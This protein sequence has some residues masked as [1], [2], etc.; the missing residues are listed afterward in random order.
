MTLDLC[1]V[2]EHQVGRG[3]NS[4]L[5]SPHSQHT[6]TSTHKHI[7]TCTHA[8][9]HIHM[10]TW[11]Q[12]CMNTH[13]HKHAYELTW[14]R[15]R[16]S[17]SETTDN[18]PK[19]GCKLFL[20]LSGFSQESLVKLHMCVRGCFR[21]KA[22]PANYTGFG[23][24][25]VQPLPSLLHTYFKKQSFLNMNLT[26]W[27][28]QQPALSPSVC[29][30]GRK[31]PWGTDEVPP[32]HSEPPA[33]P[34]A[35]ASE[36]L[37]HSLCTSHSLTFSLEDEPDSLAFMTVPAP[38]VCHCLFSLSAHF[39]FSSVGPRTEWE[40]LPTPQV[41]AQ[42]WSQEATGMNGW[43]GALKASFCRNNA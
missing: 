42:V 2:F 29:S 32:C 36:P 28:S 11:T 7:Y 13:T 26:M 40:S 14:A 31:P 43:L 39:H 27:L 6:H 22:M 20:V 23:I 38:P 12:T 33:P 19:L 35:V 18:G 24:V 8:H 10:R 15:T 3:E 34:L 1:K 16:T 5:A 25:S 17:S 41:L 9:T 4:W 30:S 21:G 37:G